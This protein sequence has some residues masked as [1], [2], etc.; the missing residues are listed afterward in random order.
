MNHLLEPPPFLLAEQYAAALT[1]LGIAMCWIPVLPISPFIAVVGLLLAYWAD[2][3]VALRCAKHT[4]AQVVYCLQRTSPS[5]PRCSPM[6][7]RCLLLQAC[8]SS[9]EHAGQARQQRGA[10][11][12]PA[13]LDTAARDETFILCGE[14]RLTPTSLLPP[15]H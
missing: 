8:C 4:C 13:A 6:P 5:P 15:R 10:P 7:P 12:P 9:W 2:K 1:T 3:F 14:S 11:H